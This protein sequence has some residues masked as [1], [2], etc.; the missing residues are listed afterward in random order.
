MRYDDA[1]Q[2]GSTV[3]SGPDAHPDIEALAPGSFGP[4]S[5]NAI[6]GA[7]TTSG[8]AGADQVSAAP[9]AIVEVHGAGGQTVQ[10]N[11][12]FQASGQYGLLSMT[13]DGDFNYVRNPC[14]P[15]G[16]Q[17][18]FNYTLADASGAT[19]ATT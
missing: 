16:V 10:A 14:T 9:A 1:S 4:A 13:A 7:G 6:S 19:S 17:D 18:V 3:A 12:A 2:A 15:D 5:G 11:G 8:Q